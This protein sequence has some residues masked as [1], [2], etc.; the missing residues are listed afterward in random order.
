MITYLFIMS[1]IEIEFRA[2]ISKNK[3]DSLNRFL[4][5]SAQDLG[6]D[7]KDTLFYILP[8][9]LHKKIH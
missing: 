5:Q 9:K 2:K 1:N 6:E 4:K 3:F 7:N 8:D